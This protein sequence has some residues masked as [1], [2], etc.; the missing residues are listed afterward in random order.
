MDLHEVGWVGKDRIALA[1]EGKRWRALLSAVVKLQVP[2]N[3][4]KDLNS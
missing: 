3:A 4:G 2:Y 1:E